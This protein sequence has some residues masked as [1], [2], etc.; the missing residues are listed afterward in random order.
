MYPY[1]QDQLNQGNHLK[2][3]TRHM[4]GLY[5]NQPG[6]RSWRRYLST[7]A[8]NSDAGIE[9]LQNALKILPKAA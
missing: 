5:K 1:I 6:A 9:V 3:I 7:H 4:L 8:H 2:H